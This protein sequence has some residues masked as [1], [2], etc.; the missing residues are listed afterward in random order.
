MSKHW[1]QNLSLFQNKTTVTNCKEEEENPND[2][3]TLLGLGVVR[4]PDSWYSLHNIKHF[5][6]QISELRLRPREEEQ[7]QYQ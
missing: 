6:K 2:N 1:S 3:L 5:I 7:Y 4:F